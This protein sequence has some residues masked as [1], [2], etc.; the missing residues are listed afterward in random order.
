M[1]IERKDEPP[2]PFFESKHEYKMPVIICPICGDKDH[3]SLT[4]WESEVNN[5]LQEDYFID[6]SFVYSQSMTYKH[7]INGYCTRCGSSF[8]FTI[9]ATVPRDNPIVSKWPR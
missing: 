5:N 8:N 6:C 1:S 3:I 2:A 4:N 7:D 9:S